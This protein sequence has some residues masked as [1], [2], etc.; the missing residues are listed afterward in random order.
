MAETFH[1][2]ANSFARVTIFGALVFLALLAG[3]GLAV[4]RSDYTTRVGVIQPQ[5][6]P[7]SH[8]HHVAGLGIDCRY[9]H[10]S[11]DVSSFAGMPATH[12]CMTCHSQIWNDSPML[13]PVRESY[14]SGRPLAWNRVHDLNDFVYFNHSIHVQKGV[15]CATCH[16]AVDE[17]PLIWKAEPMTMEW[18]LAC[19][20]AP[21]HFLRPKEAVFDMAYQPPA[22]Q[23]A[24]GRQLIEE[25]HIVTQRLTDC[26]ICHR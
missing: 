5:P 21:E 6:A 3:I 12:T 10:A 22:D 11:V 20:R 9:C 8:G 13:A 16:G 17:M 23:V 7:F 2:S 15:G 25:Y 14:I 19:H 24:L 4:A 18:C 1:P 26:Y